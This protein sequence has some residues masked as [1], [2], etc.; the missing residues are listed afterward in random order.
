MPSPAQRENEVNDE[1][2]NLIFEV[3]DDWV[4]R[5]LLCT[6]AIHECFLS[7]TGDRN[8]YPHSLDAL[9]KLTLSE[10]AVAQPAPSISPV[11]LRHVIQ[12]LRNG[13]DPMK[14]ADELEMLAAAPEAKP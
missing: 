10:A 2:K 8:K 4:A 6:H 11:A 13:C 7:S 12:W 1:I 3:C 14:A 5:G 9:A